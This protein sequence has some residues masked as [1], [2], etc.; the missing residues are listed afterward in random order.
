MQ[1]VECGLI[2]EMLRIAGFGLL[3]ERGDLLLLRE[4][5]LIGHFSGVF[6]A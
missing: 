3:L 6:T 2:C 5:F 1:I 4:T